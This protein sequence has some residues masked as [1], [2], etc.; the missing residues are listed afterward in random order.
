MAL[1]YEAANLLEGWVALRGRAPGARFLPVDRYGAPA[2]HEGR[3]GHAAARAALEQ[4][5]KE[6]RL[7]RV[8][9]EDL[10]RTGLVR[11]YEAGAD[12]Y[13][14]ADVAGF[15]SLRLARL[16]EPPPYTPRRPPRTSGITAF[17]AW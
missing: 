17:H 9:P 4:R 1:G 5:S 7:P 10:R 16:H 14:V 12:P 11:L 2:H 8:A 15:D 13:A 6:A 3:V